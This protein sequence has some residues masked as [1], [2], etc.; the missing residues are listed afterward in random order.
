MILRISEQ[1][2][3]ASPRLPSAKLLFEPGWRLDSLPCVQLGEDVWAIVF[4]FSAVTEAWAALSRFLDAARG[5]DCWLVDERTGAV[6]P[7]DE[8]VVRVHYER[9][10]A[11]RFRADPQAAVV[12]AANANERERPN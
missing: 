7:P 10:R 8:A 9:S 4:R 12:E 1:A 11:K 5:A 3:G 2:I 6:F